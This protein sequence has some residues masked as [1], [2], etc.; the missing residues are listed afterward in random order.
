MIAGWAIGGFVAGILLSVV[1]FQ[2]NTAPSPAVR[3]GLRLMMS[4]IPAGFGIICMIIMA[5]YH[6]NEKKMAGIESDLKA[7]RIERGETAEA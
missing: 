7:R 4:L 6:L 3:E 2:A 5:L 1:G